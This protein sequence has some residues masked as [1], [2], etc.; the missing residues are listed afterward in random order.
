L[1][2]NLAFLCL[3]RLIQTR[4]IHLMSRNRLFLLAVVLMLAA[5]L[6]SA[7]GPA[8]VTT[9]A[10]TTTAP[11]TTTA[12]TAAGT[13]AGTTA[14][15]TTAA[16]D[17]SLQKVLDKK[18]FVLGLDDSFPPMGFRNE[19]NEIV[20]FD[21]DLATEVTKRMGVALK[22]QPI[23]WAQKFS[24]LNSGL[25]DCIWNGYSLDEE[26]KRETNVTDPY[27]KNRQVVV[28]RNDSTYQT[29]ADLKDKKLGVQAAS[30]ATSALEKATDFK[31]SLKEVVEFKE[32]VTALLDLEAK[33]TDALLIDEIVA[34][35]YI[36][37]QNKPFRILDESLAG[38][39][40]GIGFRKNDQ[41]LRDEVQKQL[42]AMA[43]D[44]TLATISTKWF[45]KDITTIK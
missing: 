3:I 38:E 2:Q 45:G 14:A 24:E 35:Y 10:A 36:T 4:R 8:A 32:N 19:K 29:L 5:M 13:T 16:A 31:A 25:I 12:S 43:A 26:R 18:E 11:A 17:P 15:T 6:L 41:S 28:V 23:D 40:Y 34:G 44:G 1:N 42:K 27:L 21:I 22:L 7:C 37:S 20:G 39:E 30:T 33:G 9:T